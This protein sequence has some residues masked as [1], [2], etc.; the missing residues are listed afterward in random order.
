MMKIITLRVRQFATGNFFSNDGCANLRQFAPRSS[1][2]KHTSWRRQKVSIHAGYSG[3]TRK[4]APSLRQDE[5]VCDKCAK[6]LT[7][8]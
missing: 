3:F 1:V 2:A 7:L 6:L 8:S 4:S 5:T